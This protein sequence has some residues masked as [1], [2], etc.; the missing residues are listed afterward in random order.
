MNIREKTCRRSRRKVR[1]MTQGEEE[2]EKEQGG[3][4]NLEQDRRVN[5]REK[6]STRRSRGES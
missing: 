6:T 2:Y 3:R 4:A 5:I 1:S